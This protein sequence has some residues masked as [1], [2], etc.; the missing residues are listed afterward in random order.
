MFRTN[1]ELYRNR[2]FESRDPVGAS[3]SRGQAPPHVE[4]NVRYF[5]NAS[6]FFFCVNTV[7]TV[8]KCNRLLQ[9]AT[10][11]E[12]IFFLQKIYAKEKTACSGS[13]PLYVRSAK[14]HN[15]MKPVPK[16]FARYRRFCERARTFESG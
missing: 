14:V 15:D 8:S 9:P 3:L 12:T 16:T 1:V 2:P 4:S 6:R 5:E 13:V 7:S 10:A 11:Q